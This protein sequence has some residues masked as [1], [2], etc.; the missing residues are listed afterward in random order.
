MQETIDE[1]YKKAD[2]VFE[3]YKDAELRDYMLE[4][5][6]KLQDADA[7]YHHFGYLLM[8]VR[9]SVAHIVR[10]RHLQEAIERAQQFLKNY[11]AEKK[12]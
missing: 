7:M 1:L 5:A 8:H 2:A 6:Q 12:K 9:A 11:G 3:K 10:P 4:L